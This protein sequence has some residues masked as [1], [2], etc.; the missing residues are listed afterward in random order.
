MFNSSEELY[1]FMH[2]V[3]ISYDDNLL[4]LTGAR[5]ILIL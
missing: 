3:P 2:D 1:D 4:S 5:L